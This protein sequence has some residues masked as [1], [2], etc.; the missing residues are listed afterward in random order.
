M[1][2]TLGLGCLVPALLLAALLL[3]FAQTSMGASLLGLVTR[4][5]GAMLGVARAHDT[6]AGE[7]TRVQRRDPPTLYA[8]GSIDFRWQD[9]DGT[10]H[11]ETRR[12][13]QPTEKFRRLRTGD[14]IAVWVCRNDRRR[15][16]LVGYGTHEPQGC[17][18]PPGAAT[19]NGPP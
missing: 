16:K 15:V 6:V 9:E 13:I 5:G 1:K 7:V 11:D 10:T 2:R 3:G 14:R 18:G 8:A 19:P 12:V 17:D 4:F